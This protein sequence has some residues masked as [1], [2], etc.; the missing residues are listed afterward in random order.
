MA[1]HRLLLLR[2]A[3][4]VDTAHGVTDHERPLTDY[5]I[6]Q[7]TAVGAALRSRGAKPDRVVCSTAV[8]AK[9]TWNAL[10]L[11][12]PVELADE[13]YNAGS[14]SILERVRLVEEEA[15]TALIIGHGPGLPTLA[16]QLAGPGSDQRALDVVNSRYPV[17]TISEFEIDGPWADLQAGRLVWLRLGQ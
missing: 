9:Q 6:E 16:A 7:S 17:A 14:D 2:H 15:T 4:A 10:G 8:R 12:A 13:L 5:G 3:Q 1:H 11:D